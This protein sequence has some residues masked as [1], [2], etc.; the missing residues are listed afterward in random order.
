MEWLQFEHEIR[1]LVE[2]F[3]YEAEATTPSHDFGV[4]VLAHNNRRTVVVQC[5]LYGKGKIGGD[6][7]M[8][9]VGSRQYFKATDALCI[10]T[11]RFTK[12]AQKIAADEDIKLVDCDKLI[13]LCRERNLTV[14][15]LT[16]LLTS[17]EEALELQPTETRIGRGDGNH[18][19]VPSPLAS[20]H[21]AVL[22]RNKMLLTLHDCGSTNGTK[23]NGKR[24]TGPVTLN[25]D[26]TIALGGTVLTLTMRTPAGVKRVQ[27]GK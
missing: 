1:D 23:I 21:H 24:I 6:T 14:P 15:S 4:D 22:R 7:M 3:G 12:Q 19:N 11:S 27:G 16:V 25:Y 10:T 18:I 8:K 2:A 9:L 13:L 17:A 20:R 26:D 5:K